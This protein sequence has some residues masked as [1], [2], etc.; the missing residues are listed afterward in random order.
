VVGTCFARIG[1]VAPVAGACS[2]FAYAVQRGWIG[3]TARLATAFVLA[4]AAVALAERAR[5]RGWAAPAQA[6]AA[7]GIALLYLTIW[8]ASRVYGYIPL[9]F[10]LV[11]LSAV[12]MLG[13]ALA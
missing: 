10:A 13:T 2:A 12:V 5:S 8:A 6:L 7:S 4:L 3:P 1:A 11:M 9:T